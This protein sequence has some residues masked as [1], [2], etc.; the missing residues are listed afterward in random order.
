MSLKKY[1]SSIKTI[2]WN[3]STVFSVLS[4]FEVLNFFFSEE[5][6]ERMKSQLGDKASKFNIENFTA[7]TDTCEF[8]VS[9]VGTIGLEIIE[10]ENPKLVKIKNFK[11][12][13]SFT[14]W[15]QILPKGE[16]ECKMR[17]S[18]HAE[19]NMMMQMMV[20]KKLDGGI[21]QFADGIAKIPYGNIPIS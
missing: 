18:L 6:I 5:N 20:G 2:P 14:M 17:L 8:T 9:P 11:G 13:V 10:R 19:L 15:I 4:N 16:N 12:P 1:E 21:D 3:D 7:T